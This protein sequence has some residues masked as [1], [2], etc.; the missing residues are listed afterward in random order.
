MK[1]TIGSLIEIA[2]NLSIALCSILIF[3]IPIVPVHEHGIFLHFKPRNTYRLKVRG[4]KKIFHA[5]GEQNK[6]GVAMFI[7]DKI[8]FEIKTMI[9]NKEGHYIMIK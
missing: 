8:D 1:N 9:R 3:T 5:N 4:W 6:E 7:S 2:L